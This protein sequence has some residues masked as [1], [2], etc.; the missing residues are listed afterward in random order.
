MSKNQN[1]S[2]ETGRNYA[3]NSQKNCGRNSYESS[4]NQ[5]SMD[6]GSMSVNSRNCHR[7]QGGCDSYEEEK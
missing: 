6:S 2:S 7:E 4:K 3:K 1:K 5:N